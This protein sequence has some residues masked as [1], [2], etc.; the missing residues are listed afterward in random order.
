M[1]RT[2]TDLIAVLGSGDGYA[3]SGTP[4]LIR[5]HMIRCPLGAGHQ[6]RSRLLCS[7]H[8]WPECLLRLDSDCV[9]SGRGAS[10]YTGQR[11]IWY[12]IS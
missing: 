8:T 1:F 4:K 5:G 11:Q 2:Y 10:G 12:Q 3:T 7:L 9:F 6:G